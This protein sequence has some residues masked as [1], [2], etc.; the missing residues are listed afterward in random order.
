MTEGAQKE[1]SRPSEARK[2][3]KRVQKTDVNTVRSRCGDAI[4]EAKTA[5]AVKMEEFMQRRI[6][7]VQQT[8]GETMERFRERQARSCLPEEKHWKHIC[9]ACGEATHDSREE[10]CGECVSPPSAAHTDA[11]VRTAFKVDVDETIAKGK[12]EELCLKV[13]KHTR[14]V[15]TQ[16]LETASDRGIETTAI[17]HL[18]P[19]VVWGKKQIKRRKC[20]IENVGF[21]QQNWAPR[22]ADPH[23]KVWRCR[24]I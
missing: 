16:L 3:K 9:C 10:A 23:M 7:E 12:H 11:M 4:K 17:A 6:E 20:E 13:T 21:S 18:Y 2:R 14:Y 22:G 24:C 19:G 15:L 5:W 1:L 8:T